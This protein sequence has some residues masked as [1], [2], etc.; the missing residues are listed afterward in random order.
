ML[1]MLQDPAPDHHSLIR[2]IKVLLHLHFEILFCNNEI[3][4]NYLHV[5]AKNV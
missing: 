1:E 3:S 2:Q 5:A 4:G